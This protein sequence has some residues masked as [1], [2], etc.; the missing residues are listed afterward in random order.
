[1]PLRR[2]PAGSSRHGAPV[3]RPRSFSAAAAAEV[4]G[5]AA[6]G[7][8]IAGEMAPFLVKL[9]DTLA[10]ALFIDDARAVT[11]RLQRPLDVEVFGPPTQAQSVLFVRKL[12]EMETTAAVVPTAELFEVY[13]LRELARLPLDVGAEL[14]TAFYAALVEIVADLG[15]AS[16]V[17]APLLRGQPPAAA[18]FNLPRRG[19]TGRVRSS[20]VTAPVVAPSAAAAAAAADDGGAACGAS[21]PPAHSGSGGSGSGSGS[22]GGGGGGGGVLTLDGMGCESSP[23]TQLAATRARGD[24]TNACAVWLH[25]IAATAAANTEAAAGAADVGAAA[26]TRLA[27]PHT[28]LL[29]TVGRPARFVSGRATLALLLVPPSGLLGLHDL[30]LGRTLHA[31]G[32][33]AAAAIGTAILASASGLAAECAACAALPLNGNVTLASAVLCGASA[34]MCRSPTGMFVAAAAF[35]LI[36]VGWWVLDLVYFRFYGASPERLRSNRLRLLL[37]SYFLALSWGPLGAHRANLYGASLSTL[38]YSLTLGGGGVMWLVDLA[39]MPALVLRSVLL[40]KRMQDVVV[41]DASAD[42]ARHRHVFA[43]DRLSVCGRPLLGPGPRRVGCCL[44]CPPTGCFGL[45]DIILGRLLHGIA[46]LTMACAGIALV[47]AAAAAARVN[48]TVRSCPFYGPAS[49]VAAPRGKCY[50]DG[51]STCT[52]ALAT[53][54]STWH[55]LPVGDPGARAG[56]LVPCGCARVHRVRLVLLR[57]VHAAPRRPADVPHAAHGG[58]LPARTVGPVRGA[59]RVPPAQPARVRGRAVLLHRRIRGR[60]LAL[61]PLA[62]ALAR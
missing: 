57:R 42:W 54:S 27:W 22:G 4:T 51:A 19:S 11:E 16:A 47:A 33:L 46:R 20:T 55:V 15:N 2:P 61:R 12:R 13:A 3:E 9:R 60:W 39:T 21:Q 35:L 14:A 45:H 53:T 25:V 49:C 52:P 41:R 1:M 23:G 50:F 58:V 62:N 59:V 36:P 32:R 28:Q 43:A 17:I 29:S 26:A 8:Y 56:V 48:C 30:Y 31:S 37:E 38:V 44:L 24:S 10:R 18:K 34:A 40:S 6:A 5:L 7:R